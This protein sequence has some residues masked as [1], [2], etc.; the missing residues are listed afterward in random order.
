MCPNSPESQ[1]YPG[2]QQKKHGQQ[3][4]GGDPAP[5]LCAVE[6]SPGVLHAGVEPSEQER[7]RP[8]GVCP[9]DSHKNEPR[10]GTPLLQAEELFSLEMRRL[11]GDWIV[12][13]SI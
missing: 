7:H 4:K 9:E 8:V 11:R 3:V 12:A 13:F 1:P 5:L 6:A 10:D 2:P